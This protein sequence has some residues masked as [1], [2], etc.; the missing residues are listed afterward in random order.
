MQA[1]NQQSP[2][3]G[4][5]IIKG[6]DSDGWEVPMMMYQDTVCI[7]H[8][9]SSCNLRDSIKTLNTFSLLYNNIYNV[10]HANKVLSCAH[11]FFLCN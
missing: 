4:L 3:T 2:S 7:L 11:A 5:L 1:G 9:D 8:N 6:G 10:Y